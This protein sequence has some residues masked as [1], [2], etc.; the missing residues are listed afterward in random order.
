MSCCARLTIMIV[1]RYDSTNLLYVVRGYHEHEQAGRARG[2]PAPAPGLQPLGAGAARAPPP[3]VPS[4]KPEAVRAAPQARASGR[5]PQLLAV[6]QPDVPQCGPNLRGRP[7]DRAGGRIE[8]APD[9]PRLRR[10]GRAGCAQAAPRRARHRWRGAATA[11]SLRG[12]FFVCCLYSVDVM[13]N[14]PRGGTFEIDEHHP[15]GHI[16]RSSR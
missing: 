14:M 9:L 5:G 4:R 8:R 1:R 6:A 7:V 15:G 12:L 3:A 11:R 13:I 2:T 16:R 10:G